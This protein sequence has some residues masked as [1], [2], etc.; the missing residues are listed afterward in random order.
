MALVHY[1][2]IG[3]FIPEQGYVRF[4]GHKPAVTRP[5]DRATVTA[6]LKQYLGETATP[7]ELP[8]V[9][10]MSILPDY[11]VCDLLGS[12]AETLRFVAEY[13]EE[14]G[15]VILNQGSFSLMT[16]AQVRESATIRMASAPRVEAAAKSGA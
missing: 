14:T 12:P 3:H 5:V 8:D 13:A 10:A 6:L 4:Q 1:L 9:W 2:Y 15:A 16:P 11:I 7:N